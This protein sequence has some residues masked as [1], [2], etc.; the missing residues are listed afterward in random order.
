VRSCQYFGRRRSAAR[1]PGKAVLEA[2]G[3]ERQAIQ[4]GEA[5]RQAGAGADAARRKAEAAEKT[6]TDKIDRLKAALSPLSAKLK[7]ASKRPLLC[8]QF[9]GWD[10]GAL[11]KISNSA[12]SKPVWSIFA[13]I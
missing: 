11:Y 7:N 2:Q 8:A 12:L 3:K 4:A 5:A 9:F 10:G 13:S 1:S 6:S